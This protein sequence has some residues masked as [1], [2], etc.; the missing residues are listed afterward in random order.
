MK[1]YDPKRKQRE[2]HFSKYKTMLVAAKK[3]N[4]KKQKREREIRVNYINPQT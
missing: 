2:K 1:T 3:L 4:K